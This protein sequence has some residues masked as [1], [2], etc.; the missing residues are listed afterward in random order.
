MCGLWRPLLDVAH[1]LTRA[2]MFA[3]NVALDTSIG[4]FCLLVCSW[5]MLIFSSLP[6]LRLLS[7]TALEHAS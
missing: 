1:M 2:Y 4:L 5:G 6:A 3:V 7:E